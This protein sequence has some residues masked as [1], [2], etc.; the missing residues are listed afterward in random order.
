[1]EIK[2]VIEIVKK[3]SVPTSYKEARDVYYAITLHTKGVRPAFKDLSKN[4]NSG[5]I[6]PPGYI[7]GNYQDLFEKFILS[8]HPREEEVTRW[9]RY[10]QYKPLTKSAFQR[11]IKV[12]RGLIYQDIKHTLKIDDK[13]NSDYLEGNNFQEK[14]NFISLFKNII[15]Q[16]LFEDPN[17]FIV[18]IPSKHRLETIEENKPLDISFQ[19]IRCIDILYQDDENL[20]YKTQDDK[21]SFWINKEDIIRF[22][23]NEKSEWIQEEEGYFRHDFK[24]L[25]SI[26]LGGV[27]DNGIYKSFIDDAIPYA[28]EYISSYSSEQLIDKEASHPYI[29]QALVECPTCN[30]LGTN[31]EVVDVCEIYPNGTRQ[32]EC[33]TCQGKKQISINPA[34]RYEVPVNE[35]DKEMVKIINPDVNINQYHRN[36]NKDLF[37]SILDALNLLKVDAAQSGVAKTIDRDNLYQFTSSISDRLFEL[38][39]FCLK[40]FI[41]YRTPKPKFEGGFT[42]QK[43]YKFETQTALELLTEL[44][45]AQ[46]NGTPLHV[47]KYLI[48]EF[49]NKRYKGNDIDLKINQIY[50]TLDSTFGLSLTEISTAKEIGIITNDDIQNSRTIKSRVENIILTKTKDY[51]RQKSVEELINEINNMN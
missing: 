50:A 3:Q 26:K 41:A 14:N 43:P 32:V 31:Q 42:L 36:K 34:E 17:G 51:I 10:S 18:I 45:S 1:M 38:K 37:N 22:E 7:D 15:L 12:V 16:T 5:Y 19:Y 33:K 13:S 21:Y 27:Y 25:P 30:G 47:R 6:K 46:T 11:L 8:R 4:N 29:Q 28:D 40:C 39:D 20:I 2:E 9:W 24:F 23:K 49:V 44:T 35:M 48:N